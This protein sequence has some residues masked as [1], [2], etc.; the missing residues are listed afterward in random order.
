RLLRPG[1]TSDVASISSEVFAAP[2]RRDILHLCLMY[3][4][5]GQRQ[6]S[7]STKTRGD[8]RG[9]GRKLYQQKG[10]GRARVGDGQSPI[11]RGGGVAFGPKPR[12]FST[13]L[14]RKVRR[15]GM[16]IAWSARVREGGL[17]V[18][19]SLAWPHVKTKILKERLEQ[20]GWTG[21]TLFISGKEEFP[22]EL[23][24]SARNLVGIETK[25]AKDVTIHDALRW[26]RIVMDVEAV[27]FYEKTL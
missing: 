4:L 14:P 3:Y 23:A 24:R 21:R 16:R 12:D 6:G 2:I 18:V 13:R 19:D 5:D 1:E 26:S 9:S 15:M 8:V 25:Q 17:F 27:D 20:V 11:R 7:A 22:A 10:T